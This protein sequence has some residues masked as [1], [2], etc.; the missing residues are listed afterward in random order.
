MSFGCS[1]GGRKVC[2]CPVWLLKESFFSFL[3]AK[4][5]YYS[6]MLI[7]FHSSYLQSTR[8]EFDLPEYSVRRRYQDFDWLRSKLEESQPTHLIPVGTKSWQLVPLFTCVVSPEDVRSALAPYMRGRLCLTL[9]TAFSHQTHVKHSHGCWKSV[10]HPWGFGFWFALIMLVSWA[11]W[12][13]FSLSLW[14]FFWGRESP[15]S[16]LLPL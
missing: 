15:I 10:S 4:R 9:Y 7:L 2:S 8:V 12:G 6:L 13:R 5:C 1:F 11:A 16:Y 3:S 14:Q